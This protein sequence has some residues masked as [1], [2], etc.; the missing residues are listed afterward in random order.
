M[1]RNSRQLSKHIFGRYL[2]LFEKGNI[3]VVKKILTVKRQKKERSFGDWLRETRTRKGIGVRELAALVEG[4]CSASYISYLER[5]VYVSKDGKPTR[6]SEPIVLAL[7]MA[8]E[9]PINEARLA[10]GYSAVTSGVSIDELMRD[11]ASLFAGYMHLS[12]KGKEAARSQADAMIR[13]LMELEGVDFPSAEVKVHR[14]L[15]EAERQQR[16]R[17]RDEEYTPD[18]SGSPP[19]EEFQYMTDE[20]LR[21]SGYEEASERTRRKRKR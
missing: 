10:A 9:V 21:L 19:E 15:F 2:D 3:I 12:R 20:E 13:S 18:L 14:I 5:N 6:P 16:L 7:A 4:E 11:F 1:Y 17:L 8:L